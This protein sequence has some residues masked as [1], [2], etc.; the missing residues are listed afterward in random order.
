MSASTRFPAM[1]THHEEKRLASLWERTAAN[2]LRVAA[3]DMLFA[4]F[5]DSAARLSGLLTI[6]LDNPVDAMTA[7]CKKLAM[8]KRAAIDAV[9][10]FEAANGNHPAS[11]HDVFMAMQEIT[12]NLKLSGASESSCILFQK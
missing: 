9:A 5:G 8:P 7:V 1:L 3:L 2:R 6:H 4:Q 10:M 12:F 11:A